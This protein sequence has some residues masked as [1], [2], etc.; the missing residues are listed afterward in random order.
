MFIKFLN[1]PVLVF[2]KKT[3]SDAVQNWNGIFGLIE[4]N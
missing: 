4:L 3:K 1:L 2:F